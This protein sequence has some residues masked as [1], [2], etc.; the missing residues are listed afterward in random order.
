MLRMV[1]D[2]EGK[3]AFDLVRRLPGRGAYV[4]PDAGCLALALK[5][6]KLSWAFRR[7]T[8]SP[9]P[10]EA[11]REL[12]RLL[13]RRIGGLLGLAARSGAAVSGLDAVLRALEKGQAGLLILARDLSARSKE[14]ILRRA[15]AVTCLEIGS[16]ETIG[17]SIGRPDR[18]TLAIT[19][20][21][22]S[23]AI[24]ATCELTA[25]LGLTI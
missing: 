17:A 6:K 16:M 24:A 19:D 15:G 1:R 21:S 7:P 18:G 14:T 3:V 22:W 11:L 10:E 9:R 12:G 5:D 8:S 13:A 4:C 2:T 25:S 20:A 23:A